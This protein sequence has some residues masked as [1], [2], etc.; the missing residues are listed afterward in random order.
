MTNERL[1][2]AMAT[3]HVDID[4]ITR[5]TNVDP[6]TVQR[7]VGGRIPHQRHRWKVA[8]LLNE[9]E[10]YLWPADETQTNTTTAQTAEIV[11]AYAQRAAVPQGVPLGRGRPY[12]ERERSRGFLRS[13]AAGQSERCRKAPTP[14]RSR[15]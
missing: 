14:R 4:A 10:D 8:K 13:G 11:A 2:H 3:A 12:P 1:R 6:K 15:R 9:R 5:A 7:W